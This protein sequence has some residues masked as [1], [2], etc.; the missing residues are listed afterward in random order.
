VTCLATR[1]RCFVWCPFRSDFS[2]NP[3]RSIGPKG[4]ALMPTG[5]SQVDVALESRAFI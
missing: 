1:S 2:R 4:Q 3:A 5:K